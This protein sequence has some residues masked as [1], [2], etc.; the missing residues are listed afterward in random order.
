MRYSIVQYSEVVAAGFRIDAE[1]WHPEFIRNSALVSTAET[2]GDFVAANVANIKS[3]PIGRD[4]EYLEISGISTTGCDYRTSP[5]AKGD[6]PDRAHY[7]LE[8]WDVVVSTVRPNRNAVAIIVDD[9]IVGSSG[10]AVLRT[11]ELEPA[12]L[13]AFCKTDYFI[14]C[15]VRA[16]KATMYPAVSVRDVLDTPI[17]TGSREFR[18]LVSSCV[19]NALALQYD[20][21]DAYA[22]AETIL[23]AELELDE[24]Q[25]RRQNWSVRSYSE[26][27][28]ANRMDAEYFHPKYDRIIAAVKSY[29]GGWGE[30]DSLVNARNRNFVPDKHI[31]YKYIELANISRNGEIA[32]CTVDYGSEL[33]TRARRIAAAGDVIV[34]SIE[35]SLDSVAMIDDAYDGA[36]CSTGFYVVNS[37][38]LNS[39]TLMMLLKSPVG[40]L[41]LK[42]GCSGTILTAINSDEF[43][44]IVLPIV[45]DDRQAEIR[46]RVA[47][48]TSLRQQSR[49]LLERAKRAVEIAIEQ[50]EPA[51]LRWLEA[52]TDTITP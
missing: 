9:G 46:R 31:L 7:I 38:I 3:S 30:L 1:Y 10:L 6:E 33:P 14:K 32:D 19:I 16:N 37:Q 41:Q 28:A 26:T 52:E 22:A 36:L 21:R 49:R 27:L 17:F 35:G 25:P 24:W 15:L 47:E 18:A 44:K 8:P 2:I 11:N 45:S 20:A 4:F 39:E 23:L 40:Q 48:A 13:F 29:A 51:A 12:Y 42:R 50:G 43:G 34:S 5:I